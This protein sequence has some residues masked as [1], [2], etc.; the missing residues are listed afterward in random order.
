V[1]LRSADQ[2]LVIDVGSNTEVTRIGL[3]NCPPVPNGCQPSRLLFGD[4]LLGRAFVSEAGVDRIAVI[5]TDFGFVQSEIPLVCPPCGC[6]PDGLATTPGDGLLLVANA[7][8]GTLSLIR[9]GDVVATVP[10]FQG[11]GMVSN[12]AVTADGSTAFVT[13]QDSG[14]LGVVDLA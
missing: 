6:G 13:H 3:E 8:S 4:S 11:G 7:R 5:D 1:A 10:V 12:V 2:V 9:G 14:M